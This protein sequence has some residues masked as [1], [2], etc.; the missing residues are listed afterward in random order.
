VP[1]SATYYD[2]GLGATIRNAHDK[3]DAIK[4]INDKTGMSVVEAGT[5]DISKHCKPQRQEYDF[6]RGVFDNCIRE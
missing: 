1:H 3:R 4:R 2:L 5:E 6:P